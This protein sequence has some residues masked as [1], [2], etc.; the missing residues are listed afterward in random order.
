MTAGATSP[1]DRGRPPPRATTAGTPTPVH[2]GLARVGRT[3]LTIVAVGAAFILGTIVLRVASDDLR[4]PIE[5]AAV[6]D[7]EAAQGTGDGFHEVEGT[8]VDRVGPSDGPAGPA[9]DRSSTNGGATPT[10]RG[11]AGPTTSAAPTTPEPGSTGGPRVTVPPVPTP[12]VTIP[13]VTTPP[14]TLP[15][16][17]LPPLTLPPVSPP[18]PPVS[19]PTVSLPPVSLPGVDPS[20]PITVPTLPPVSLP[21]L[22]PSAVETP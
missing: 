20:L 21:P 4:E 14:V 1:I 17:S 7:A 13:A 22:F 5:L 9:G 6:P 15:P 16:V 18:P 19:I 3:T 2:H 11:A 8:R 12:S 10:T